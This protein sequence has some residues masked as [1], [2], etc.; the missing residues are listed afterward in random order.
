MK[1]EKGG[2]CGTYG[3]RERCAQ[4]FGEENGWKETIGRKR[5]RWEDNIKMDLH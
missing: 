4:G 5:R 2:T 3:L 1:N